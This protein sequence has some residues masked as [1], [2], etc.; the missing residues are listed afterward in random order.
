[1]PVPEQHD[2]PPRRQPGPAATRSGCPYLT[3]PR[4]N[5]SVTCRVTPKQGPKATIYQ[6]HR[7]GTRPTIV[8]PRLTRRPCSASIAHNR[9]GPREASRRRWQDNELMYPVTGG[10]DAC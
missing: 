6:A 1:M 5:Q 8:R 9:T 7:P 4:H 3:N 10:R 2:E